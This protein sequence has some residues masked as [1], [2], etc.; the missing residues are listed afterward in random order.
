MIS[1]SK[2]MSSKYITPFTKL[3]LFFG[4]EYLLILSDTEHFPNLTGKKACV[5]RMVQEKGHKSDIMLSTGHYTTA[6]QLTFTP[7]AA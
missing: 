7:R 2:Q 3:I 5:V 1:R 4:W 6:S